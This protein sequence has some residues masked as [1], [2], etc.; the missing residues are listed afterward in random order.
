[1]N[2]S[3]VKFNVGGKMFEVNQTLLLKFPDNMMLRA[4]AEMSNNQ[5]EPI[6]IDRDGDRF[7]HV[8]D[9]MRDGKQVSLPITISTETFKYDLKYYG[10]DIKD[11][12]Y[13]FNENLA[14]QIIL[15]VTNHEDKI[16]LIDRQMMQ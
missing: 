12:K 4:A 1:M 2:N 8:L 13:I 14:S 6:F 3:T 15:F 16:A 10:I 9:Y 7:V 5:N 11:S